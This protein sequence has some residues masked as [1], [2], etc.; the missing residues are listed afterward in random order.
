[1]KKQDDKLAS[2]S[3]GPIVQLIVLATTDLH[4]SLRPYN[5]YLDRRTG[6]AGLA[7]IATLVERIRAQTPNCLLLD[8][9][10]TLQGTP[11]GD[12]AA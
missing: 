2:D 1:M 3:D 8:N 4:A 12:Y 11:L 5:Y 10:D 7:S 6:S 9:G